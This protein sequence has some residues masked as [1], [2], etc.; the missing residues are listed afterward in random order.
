MK[1][2]KKIITLALAAAM[3]S[4]TGITAFAA[5]IDQDTTPPTGTTSVTM[6]VA[7]SYT[8]TIPESVVLNEQQDGTY[9]NDAVIT[10][11]NIRL[12]NNKVVSVTMDSDFLLENAQGAAA[13]PYTLTI[14]DAEKASGDT[15]ATFATDADLTLVQQSD[16]LHF[17]A[18][19]P[20]FAGDYSDTVTFNI[21]VADAS[22]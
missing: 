20:T 5:D 12:N 3:L 9:S 19:V 1:N 10:A 18:D 11:T 16:T 17:A 2:T 8:V 14:N 7:P 13:L 6:S 21:A 15:V 4:A 22:T